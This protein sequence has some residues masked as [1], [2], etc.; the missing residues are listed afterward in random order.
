MWKIY[1]KSPN[2]VGIQFMV[3]SR[4]VLE[5][6]FLH[7]EIAPST[8]TP[9]QSIVYLHNFKIKLTS[10]ILTIPDVPPV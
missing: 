2:D 8:T 4:L 1:H 7:R 3:P 9:L 10:Y 6:K 5:L